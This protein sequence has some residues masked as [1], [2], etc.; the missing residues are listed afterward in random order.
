MYT[1]YSKMSVSN[2]FADLKVH[3]EHSEPKYIDAGKLDF[4]WL[5]FDLSSDKKSDSAAVSQSDN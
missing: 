4:S 2:D 5:P 1:D 3:I